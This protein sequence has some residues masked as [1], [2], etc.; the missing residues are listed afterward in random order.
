VIVEGFIASLKVTAIF[1][2]LATPVAPLAGTVKLTVGARGP[3]VAVVCEK[4]ERAHKS[5][6]P[7]R[8]RTDA[9]VLPTNSSL[10]S[11]GSLV[12]VFAG[13]DDDRRIFVLNPNVVELLMSPPDSLVNEFL[14]FCVHSF[15]SKETHIT[16]EFLFRFDGW[17]GRTPD[18]MQ[19]GHFYGTD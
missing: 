4:A 10:V 13:L 11:N 18:A 9:Q 1:P 12:E 3:E 2:L 8:A 6:R 7:Q 19:S 14:K 15:S 17:P 16:F 5:P